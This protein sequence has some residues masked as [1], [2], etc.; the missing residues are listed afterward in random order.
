MANAEDQHRATKR[1]EGIRDALRAKLR[2]DGPQAAADL[3]PHFPA[4]V[5]LSEVAF[6]LDRLADEGTTAGEVGSA[7]RLT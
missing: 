7:Y 1:G 4:D 5:S 3:R 2:E 6:Q